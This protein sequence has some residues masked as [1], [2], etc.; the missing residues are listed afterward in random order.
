M[1]LLLIIIISITILSNTRWT[2]LPLEL[3]M[4]MLRNLKATTRSSGKLR[5][6]RQKL[7]RKRKISLLYWLVYLCSSKASTKMSIKILSCRMPLCNMAPKSIVWFLTIFW[8]RNWAI[9]MIS[10]DQNSSMEIKNTSKYM[11]A[12]ITTQLL[13]E[14]YSKQLQKKNIHQF[15]PCSNI[16]S[17]VIMITISIGLLEP[18]SKFL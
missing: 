4:S 1:Q 13:A 18:S 15:L 7:I 6:K 2:H 8:K 14:N 11:L 12:T 17:E 3:L 9:S 5:A 16:C 10:K